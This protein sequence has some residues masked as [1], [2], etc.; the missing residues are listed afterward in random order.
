MKYFA[1]PVG[2]I[3]DGYQLFETTE[4]VIESD[5]SFFNPGWF[6]SKE[7]TMYEWKM[8]SKTFKTS[9]FFEG[10]TI[11]GGMMAQI[12]STRVNHSRSIYNFLDFL[13]DVG[14]LQEAFNQLGAAFLYFFG[15]RG[16]QGYLIS[17]LFK[18]ES[19][20]EKTQSRKVFEKGN[21]INEQGVRLSQYLVD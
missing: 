4:N 10:K 8:S 16:L 11:I 18:E 21:D 2:E 15:T 20:E 13:G 12:S 1:Q 17:A 6:A 9:G 5:E 19:H 3:T 7:L 14:G